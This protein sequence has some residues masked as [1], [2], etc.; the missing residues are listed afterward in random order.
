MKWSWFFSW[1]LL[2][3]YDFQLTQ[4][5][6][7]ALPFC[8]ETVR[9][10]LNDGFQRKVA[11]TFDIGGTMYGPIMGWSDHDVY[12]QFSVVGRGITICDKNELY[13]DIL[14]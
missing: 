5:I 6:L 4:P 13:T 3:D 9:T 14:W 10:Y 12:D 8:P 1:S 11:F 2:H 7:T